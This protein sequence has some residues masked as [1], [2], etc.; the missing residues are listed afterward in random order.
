MKNVL[1]VDDE[2]AILDVFSEFL[3][4][5]GY[6]VKILEDGLEA[7]TVLHR[8][9]FDVLITDLEMPTIH[10]LDIISQVRK[11]NK[12]IIIIALSGG[13]RTG[14]NDNLNVAERV[15]ADYSMQKPFHGS[16]LVSKVNEL[17]AIKQTA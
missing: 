14:L 12:D 13:A 10:G 17:V 11:E 3:E 4:M 1:F 15:G 16:E 5:S 2:P 8:E 7:M 9:S 6:K